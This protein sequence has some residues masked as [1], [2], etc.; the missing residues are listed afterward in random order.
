MRAWFQSLGLYHSFIVI[1]K[2]V[3]EI[4]HLGQM[5][6]SVNEGLDVASDGGRLFT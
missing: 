1:K 4:N 5:E 3:V 6:K 2:R